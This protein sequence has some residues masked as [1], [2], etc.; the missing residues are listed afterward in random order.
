MQQATKHATG[1]T[2][3]AT[4]VVA[5]PAKTPAYMVVTA[6]AATALGSCTHDSNSTCSSI[7]NTRVPTNAAVYPK[8]TPHAMATALKATIVAVAAAKD[9]CKRDSDS[10]CNSN[11]ISMCNSNSICSKNISKCSSICKSNN[12]CTINEPYSRATAHAATT[13]QRHNSC[14]SRCKHDG[15]SMHNSNNT[16]TCSKTPAHAA[17]H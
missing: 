13:A 5:A 16:G 17:V 14:D 6:D 8:A 11:S 2:P 12:T 4:K 1:I 10:T 7:P 3:K 15:N 9:S